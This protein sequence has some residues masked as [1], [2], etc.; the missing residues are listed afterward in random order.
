M[1]VVNRQDNGAT[2]IVT[3]ASQ[4]KM[5]A[6]SH[7]RRPAHSGRSVQCLD[8]FVRRP[9]A[10]SIG[11]PWF[12]RCRLGERSL[13]SGGYRGGGNAIDRVAAARSVEGLDVGGAEGQACGGCR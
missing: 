6:A 5:W 2:P 11:A 4:Q 12:H 10:Y 9:L 8:V 7:Q 3:A 13:E 1:A